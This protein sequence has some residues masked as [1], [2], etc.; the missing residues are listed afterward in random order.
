MI[1]DRQTGAAIPILTSPISYYLNRYTSHS[2]DV[3]RNKKASAIVI[4][5]VHN[6]G[7]AVVENRRS[8]A[9]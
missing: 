1:G 9:A 2:E 3:F 8:K 4:P 7:Q 5:V 6:P